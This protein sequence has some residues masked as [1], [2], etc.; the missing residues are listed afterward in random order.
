MHERPG[1]E[2]RFFRG[3]AIALM[4]SALI[5]IAGGIIVYSLLR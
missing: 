4:L 3:L 5:W 2:G 1:P